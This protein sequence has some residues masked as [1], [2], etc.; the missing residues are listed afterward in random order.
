M[1]SDI[2]RV[3][4]RPLIFASQ[5]HSLKYIDGTVYLSPQQI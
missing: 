3:N 2:T 4:I 1:F 5:C